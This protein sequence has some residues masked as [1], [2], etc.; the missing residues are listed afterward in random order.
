MA[1][2]H[3][4][5]VKG[6]VRYIKMENVTTAYINVLDKWQREVDDIR[7]FHHDVW[8]K[9]QQSDLIIQ[10]RTGSRVEKQTRVVSYGKQ[11]NIDFMFEVSGVNVSCGN[12]GSSEGIYFKPS[13]ESS[14]F[15]RVYMTKKAKQELQSNEKYSAL[16]SDDFFYWDATEQ[17]F[18]V[19]PSVFR[20]NVI[21]QSG[22]EYQRNLT[23]LKKSPSVP[24]KGVVNEYDAVPC[25]RLQNWPKSTSP[26]VRKSALFDINWRKRIVSDNIAIFLVP[27]G[28]PDSPY[29]KD[30]FRLSFSMPEIEC[31]SKLNDHVRKL[32]GL[33]K[34]VFQSLFSTIDVLGW[35]HVKYILL[36]MV[37]NNYESKVRSLSPLQFV[38]EA[39]QEIAQS[40]K[41]RSIPHFFIPTRNIFPVYKLTGQSETLY[42]NV[43]EHIESNVL[44]LLEKHLQSELKIVET[45]DWLE[46]AKL[47]LVKYAEEPSLQEYVDGYLTRL[48]SVIT[49]PLGRSDTK[50]KKHDVKKIK[51]TFLKYENHKHIDR[52]V[53]MVNATIRRITSDE[54]L[55]V[56]VG[57]Q[58]QEHATSAGD[59]LSVLAHQVFE[60]V[61]RDQSLVNL[62]KFVAKNLDD[63]FLGHE[64]GVSVTRYHENLLPMDTPLLYVMSSLKEM[65]GACPRFYIHPLLLLKHFQILHYI[66]FQLHKDSTKSDIL[67]ELLND[68]LNIALK[69]SS[70]AP[71]FGKLSYRFSAMHL[72]SGYKI[73]LK[74]S[75]INFEF[76]FDLESEIKSFTLPKDCG[77]FD[78]K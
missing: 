20:D 71:Y 29:F 11:T 26:W 34:Y 16:F 44:D 41:E 42:S 69:M 17:S 63:Q 35:F 49:F 53:P 19:K 65:Y 59:K 25:L 40:I 72:L 46:S 38:L 1:Q 7:Q 6:K 58:K 70:K 43:F 30:E 12:H 55:D 54:S 37:D 47:A 48:L 33:T 73:L 76:K 28:N 2:L 51:E 22:F 13:N 9:T 27:T 62:P 36:N 52:I 75:N 74:D 61:I 77:S 8:A 3:G 50:N 32:F 67:L 15:G 31:F 5:S 56:P 4:G 14:L 66:K 24:G 45:E 39:L 78:L 18:L 23:V 21:N 68:L 60:K 10:H 64:I 57:N